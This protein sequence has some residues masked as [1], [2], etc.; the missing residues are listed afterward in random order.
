[1]VDDKIIGS[2]VL[3]SKEFLE[4]FTL[5]TS[6][7]DVITCLWKKKVYLLRYDIVISCFRISKSQKRKDLMIVTQ[8]IN[9]CSKG[10]LNKTKKGRCGSFSEISKEFRIDENS[11]LFVIDPK[12][13]FLRLSFRLTTKVRVVRDRFFC[14]N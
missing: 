4:W 10:Y 5:N 1:M 13:R 12:V 2:L 9:R 6:F 14:S 8:E 11:F 3:P 7:S